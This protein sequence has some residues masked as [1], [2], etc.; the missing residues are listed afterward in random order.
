MSADSEKWLEVFGEFRHAVEHHVKDEENR[1]FEKAR[2][3][4]DDDEAEQ[5]AE[6]MD[7]LKERAIDKAA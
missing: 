7:R 5:L 6:R 2:K 3:V 1:I 4:L